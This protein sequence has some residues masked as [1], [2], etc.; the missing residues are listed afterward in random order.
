M[1]VSLAEPRVLLVTAKEGHKVEV[2]DVLVGEVWLGSGQ[3]NMEMAVGGA[4]NAAADQR[5]KHAEAKIV[6][7]T[8]V[9]S[10]AEVVQPVA[11]RYA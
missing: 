6:G 2:K 1:T 4:N 3:S 7:D 5:W 8:V 11:V 10:R 9:V